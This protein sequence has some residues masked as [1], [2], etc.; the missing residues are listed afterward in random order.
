MIHPSPCLGGGNALE[1][2]CP[3]LPTVH[4]VES[5]PRDVHLGSH[6]L[7]FVGV[8]VNLI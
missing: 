5:G 8:T 2:N 3:W 7:T 6:F 4:I 1:R